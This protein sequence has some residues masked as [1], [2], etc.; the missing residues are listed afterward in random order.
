M[1]Y[2]VMNPPFCT[3]PTGGH[4]V[5]EAVWL[6]PVRDLKNDKKEIPRPVFSVKAAWDLLEYLYLW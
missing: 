3:Q 6:Q 1:K 5:K 4:L 2:E